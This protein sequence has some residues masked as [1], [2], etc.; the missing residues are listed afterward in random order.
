MPTSID[1]PN[2]GGRHLR[3]LTASAID[4]VPAAVAELGLKSR[5]AQFHPNFKST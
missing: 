4:F 1:A 2:S 5:G 3:H